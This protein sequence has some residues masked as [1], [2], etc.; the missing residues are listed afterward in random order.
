MSEKVLKMLIEG[1]KFKGSDRQFLNRTN[2]PKG[3]L[4]NFSTKN[5]F[6]SMVQNVDFSFFVSM[7]DHSFSIFKD[8]SPPHA[9]YSPWAV[10]QTA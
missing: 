3:R 1:V 5:R 10:L 6:K 8:M 2:G 4:N 9:I 7:P